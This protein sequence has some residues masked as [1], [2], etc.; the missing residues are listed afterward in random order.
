MSSGR[1][2]QKRFDFFISLARWGVKAVPVFMAKMFYSLFSS[3]EGRVF[4][5]LRYIFLSRLLGSL[6]ESVYVGERVVIRNQDGVNFGTGVSVHPFSY[7]D[8]YGGLEVGD[9]VSI[10][11]NVSILTFE[12][13]WE[14]CSLPIKYNPVRSL[15]VT[16][17]ND[18]WI[19]CGVRILGGAYI[20]SRVVVAAGAVV[21]GRLE[22]G[23]I[24]GGVPA[25]KLRPL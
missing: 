18:V 8:G 9:Y 21:K 17:E 19:G 25:K 23:W 7:I 20:E 11:H 6:G 10:A 12:Y 1:D 22:G 3:G 4:V 24:Y 13:Q 2:L 16:I 15:P 5:F 14:D